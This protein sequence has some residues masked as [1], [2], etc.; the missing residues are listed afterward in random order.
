MSTPPA[1]AVRRATEDDLAAVS[2][3]RR[4]WVAERRSAAAAGAAA[5][6]A[7]AAGAAAATAAGADDDPDFEARMAD[8]WLRMAD[9]RH[10]WLAWAGDWPIGMAALVVFERMPAPGSPTAHWGYV[11]QVW[12]DPAY[13]RRGVA[14]ALMGAAIEWA[15]E[16]QMVRLVLNPSEISRPMY[17]ALG[18]RPA[19]DLLRLDLA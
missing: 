4:R 5:A 18:F 19:D 16:Q 6:T 9:R 8:W 12:V 14:T 13:R 3:C 2:D 10:T 11:S 17:A 15:R 1:Y 7:A